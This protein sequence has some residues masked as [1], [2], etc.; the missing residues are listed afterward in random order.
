MTR[1]RTT[2]RR[3]PISLSSRWSAGRRHSGPVSGAQPGIAAVMADRRRLPAVARRSRQWRPPTDITSATAWLQLPSWTRS[4]APTVGMVLRSPPRPT[5]RPS[6][7]DA[8]PT[9]QMNR[10][11][12]SELARLAAPTAPGR[13]TARADAD[14]RDLRRRLAQFEV[15]KRRGDPIHLAARHSQM[16]A[17]R[18]ERGRGQPTQ[19]EL[20]LVQGR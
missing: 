5:S 3:A 12:V 14:A 17:D 2:D 7:S 1:G 8:G 6:T 20:Y 15:R 19:R 10:Q 18:L 4:S 13:P 11:S 9:P 16:S